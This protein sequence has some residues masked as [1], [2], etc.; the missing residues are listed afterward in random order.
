M[1]HPQA[2]QKLPLLYSRTDL[3]QRS[4]VCCEQVGG[5]APPCRGGS[6]IALLF[7]TSESVGIEKS[8]Q[9]ILIHGFRTRSL[10]KALLEPFGILQFYRDGWEAYERQ[11]EPLFHC[12][13]K[14]DTQKI[15][16][17]HLTLRT[18]I[19]RLAR[20]TICCSKSVLMHD[21]VIGLFINRLEFGL[22]V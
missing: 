5:A 17:K 15:E 7:L 8:L 3:V 4:Q 12:V 18:R 6:A 2:D 20:K 19:K 11:I 10:L 1:L 9:S 14:R 21:V 22:S 16:R 13:G